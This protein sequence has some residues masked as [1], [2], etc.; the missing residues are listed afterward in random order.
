MQELKDFCNIIL[1][2]FFSTKMSFR[3]LSLANDR[4]ICMM[5]MLNWGNQKDDHLLVLPNITM[6]TPFS[7]SYAC[8]RLGGSSLIF[9]VLF[10]QDWST[11]IPF[12]FDFWCSFLVW[13]LLHVH[14]FWFFLHLYLCISIDMVIYLSESLNIIISLKRAFLHWQTNSF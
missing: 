9:T 1:I 6:T 8:T 5:K 10:W 4:D 13:S 7:V 2:L 3:M 14:L 12:I 11:S